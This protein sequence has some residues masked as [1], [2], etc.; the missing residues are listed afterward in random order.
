MS[1]HEESAEMDT[2]IAKLRRLLAG[3]AYL[4]ILAR[5]LLPR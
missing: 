4:R 1:W 5:E 3:T 2:Y